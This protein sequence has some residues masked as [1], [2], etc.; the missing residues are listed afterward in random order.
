MNPIP[1]SAVAALHEGRKIEAVKRVRAELGVDLKTAKERVEEFL[2][3]D[4]L[5][6]AS[7]AEMQAR[8]G[9]LA[10]RWSVALVCVA[11]AIGYLWWSAG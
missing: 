5:V 4:P 2:R 6:K 7:Y 3:A 9:N 11:A 8:S 10:L 1:P